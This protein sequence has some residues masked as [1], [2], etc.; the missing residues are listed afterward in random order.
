VHGRHRNL[1]VAATG[2]GKTVIAA[3]DYR[4]LA[5]AAPIRPSLLFVAH[6]RE[7]LEQSLR[8]YREVLAD[9]N[10]GELYVGRARPERWEHVFA[11]VQSLTAYGI[12]NIPPGAFR[13]VV[14]D[15]FHHAEAKTYRRILDRLNPRELLGLTATPER[16]DGVDVRKFFDGRT[17]AELRLW[18]ALKADLLT[19]IHYF[20][21]ADGLDLRGVDWKA[22][23]YDPSA[24]STLVTGNDTRARVVLKALRDKVADLGTMKAVAFCVSQDHARYMAQ[25]FNDA[26]ISAATVLG[27]TQADDRDAAIAN[28]RSGTVQALFT[29]DVFNEGVDVPAINT[30][31]FLRPTE[32]ATVF[33]Q[34]LGRGLRRHHEKSL[35][36]VLDFV[37]LHRTEFRFDRRLRAL[38]QGTRGEVMAQLEAGF[39]F[40]PAGCHMEL[41]AVA[42]KIIL[43]N[44]R[45][46]VPTRW[47]AK[48]EELRRLAARGTNVSLAGFLEATGLELDEMYTGE[49]GWSDLRADADLSLLPSGPHEDVLRRACG[50]LLHVDDPVRIEAYRRLVV[51][52]H[53]D[54]ANLSAI[55]RRFA[56]MLIAQL[57]DKAVNKSTTL[58]EGA[59]LLVAHPQVRAEVRDL[60]DVL[61]TR[62]AHI[63][64]PLGT[65]PSVPLS[66]GARYTRLEVL[67]AFGVGEGAKVAPWQTGVFWAKE[68]RAD[69]LAFT[70]DKTSGQFS[71]TTRYRDYAISREL[72]HWES[73]SVTRADSETGLRYRQHVAQGSSVMLF[74]RLRNDD[75][76]FYFLGPATYVKHE[77][78]L[79]MAITWR[80]AHPL[81]G[82]LFTSFAAAVA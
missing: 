24:L 2:T 62:V 60:L 3:L 57:L 27:D 50:R 44:M 21:I 11:S 69:L 25:V 10:F 79:P 74:A 59:A 43:E 46:A 82:D 68:A 58:A 75:R 45:Q 30:V 42:S 39:P 38:L 37:G 14:I 47:A 71:P 31:L 6:R 1:V 13:I 5:A 36:T 9:P 72:V 49:R 29:V 48:V 81:P 12:E 66:I 33:L 64:R 61:S 78:E 54:I 35:C 51:D 8:T 41:D 65:H 56:R 19:P 32:S 70:L 15:E 23:S 76:A 52:D 4:R 7:I 67:A 16:G 40:L 20:A 63:S 26:G 77:G 73:Q 17:A 22:G 55:D 18:D 34:Q 80:L 28:L 53:L